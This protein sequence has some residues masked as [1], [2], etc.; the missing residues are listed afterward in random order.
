MDTRSR[1]QLHLLLIVIAAALATTLTPAPV[2]AEDVMTTVDAASDVM[3]PAMVLD[4]TGN[5]VIAYGDAS[6]GDLKIV[7]CNDPGCV[8]D[9]TLVTA[10]AAGLTGVSPSLV[11]DAAGHPVVAYGSFSPYGIRLLR[12]NDPAC[13]GGDEVPSVVFEGGLSRLPSLV[14]DASG[15]PVI[16]YHEDLS[17]EIRVVHCDDPRCAGGND[18]GVVVDVTEG[19]DQVSRIALDGAGNPLVLYRGDDSMGLMLLHCNDAR[20]EGGDDAPAVLDPGFVALAPDMT[21]DASG[22]PVIA[23]FWGVALRIV[24]CDDPGC[25][26]RTQTSVDEALGAE[27]SVVVDAAGRP[28]ITYRDLPTTSEYEAGQR[29]KLG[30]VRCGDATCT[31]VSLATLDDNAGSLGGNSS[32]ALDDGDNPIAAYF[33]DN[34]RDLML[35]RCDD[36]FCVA[37][38]LD[39]DGDGVADDAD[40]F[41]LD[42]SESADADG[43]G[44]GDNGDPDTAG[45][46]VQ[47]LPD[48]SF[49]SHGH[50]TSIL[51]RLEDAEAAITAGRTDE[52]RLM[53]LNLRRRVD[54]CETAPIAD[55]NDWIVD[56]AAQDEVRTLLD[57]LLASL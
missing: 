7:H 1:R 47:D 49:R 19:F 36:A 55:V 16:S 13:A 48:A 33:D 57:T 39:S 8:G 11:L 12:C 21:L 54:G 32:L 44:L 42:P 28:V 6:S 15:N 3:S 34:G 27:P 23:W 29:T 26:S 18:E 4:A 30:L 14:L 38:P 53:L 35:I 40:A 5:P 45:A 22:S 10:D 37:P 46:V 17:D 2:G 31:T 50:R 9:E 20:C 41:P 24:R 56:C 43:D 52:A 25:A 51:S